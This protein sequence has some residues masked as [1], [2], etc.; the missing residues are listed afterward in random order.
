M[1]DSFHER[2][3]RIEFLLLDVDGVLTD[4][5]IIY[6]DQGEEVKS[7]YVRDGAGLKLWQLAGKRAGVLTGRTSNIV[8]RRAKE[9]GLSPVIQGAANKNAA[10]E[11]LVHDQKLDPKQLCYVGDDVPDLPVLSRSG[12][13]V[14][15]ADACAEAKAAAHYVTQAPGGRGAVR[16]I[17]ELLLGAQGRWR[18]VVERFAS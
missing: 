12:L 16:E 1:N 2:C 8:N 10:F 9:L 4:G 5:S 18:E 13:A 6:S 15:V 3:R 11:H 14:A 7:F 17:V